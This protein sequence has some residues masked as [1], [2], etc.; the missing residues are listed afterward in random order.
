[1]TFV[2]SNHELSERETILFTIA[3]KNKIRYPGINLTN[4][5]K[6]L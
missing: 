2:Y 4:E 6:D 5:V 3:T 1:M